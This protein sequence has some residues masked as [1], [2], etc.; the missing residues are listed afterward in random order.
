[1]EAALLMPESPAC[2][3]GPR[4]VSWARLSTDYIFNGFHFLVEVRAREW[5]LSLPI[6]EA[7]VRL[8]G[9]LCRR[10]GAPMARV[11]S[12]PNCERYACRRGGDH[13]EYRIGRLDRQGFSEFTALPGRS[14]TG[15]AR[16]EDWR[17]EGGAS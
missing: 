12:A 8:H 7:N 5:R 15:G 13:C 10:C 4:M 2:K 3:L 14:A 6:G 1:M 16:T 11:E 17:T 9:P